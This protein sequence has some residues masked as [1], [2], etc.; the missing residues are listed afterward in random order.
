M[1]L[2]RCYVE[3]QVI[4]IRPCLS[5]GERCQNIQNDTRWQVAVVEDGQ[6]AVDG[7]PAAHHG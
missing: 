3:V 5:T 4:V 1:K 7:V 6:N 2:L